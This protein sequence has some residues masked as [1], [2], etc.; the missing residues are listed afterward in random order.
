MALDPALALS[1]N[2]YESDEHHSAIPH[3]SLRT[4][5]TQLE[6]SQRQILG[7]LGPSTDL[8]W[9]QCWWKLALVCSLALPTHTQAQQREPQTMDYSVAPNR[10]PRASHRQHLTL[11]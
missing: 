4:Y 5:L 6:H 3:D 9:A 7:C 1:L 10:L 11:T 2:L 8:P